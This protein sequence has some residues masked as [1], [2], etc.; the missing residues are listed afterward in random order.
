VISIFFCCILV[1]SDTKPQ[2]MLPGENAVKV[3]KNIAPPLRKKRT[4][5]NRGADYYVCFASWLPL[6]AIETVAGSKE[7]GLARG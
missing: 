6:H 1:N 7:S 2:F 5:I 4:G 3:D